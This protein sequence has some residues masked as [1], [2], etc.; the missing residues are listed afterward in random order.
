MVRLL[1]PRRRLVDVLAL[2]ER[3]RARAVLGL[4]KVRIA[5]KIGK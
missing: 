2:R 5:L 1:E 4:D 3:G